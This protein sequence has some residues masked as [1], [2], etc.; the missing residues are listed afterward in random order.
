MRTGQNSEQ[1]LVRT[2][3]VE[4]HD[5]E[6][7]RFV[8]W[9]EEMGKSRFANAFAYGRVKIDRL[10]DHCFKELRASARVL[11]VGCGTGEYVRRATELGFCASGI[12][13]ADAM[14]KVAIEKNP[15]TSIANGVATALPFPD[16]AFD[17]V[18]CIEVLRYLHPADN[19]LALREMHRV[20]APGGLLFLTSVNRYA[21][22][23][24]YFHYRL[25]RLFA[26]GGTSAELPHCEFTTPSTIHREVRSAGFSAAEHYGVLFAPMRILYKLATTRLASR[27]AAALEPLDDAIC[28]RPGMRPFAGHLVTIATR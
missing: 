3:A 18:I 19:K 25:R 12:E 27:I 4:H 20:L 22:D 10:L 24:Y 2:S 7:V 15:N 17:L 1:I 11:D 8:K 23:A 28:S 6:A 13:P 26:G 14:R 9:Y 16:K 5:L 21:L